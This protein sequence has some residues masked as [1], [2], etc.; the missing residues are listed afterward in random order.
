MTIDIFHE[1]IGREDPVYKI[2]SDVL[3]IEVI[4]E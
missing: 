3:I 4:L 1:K 2:T